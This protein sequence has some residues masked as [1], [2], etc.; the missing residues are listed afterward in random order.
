MGF[1]TARERVTL[2]KSADPRERGRVREP[3]RE[4]FAPRRRPTPS[5]PNADVA[6][7][8]GTLMQRVSETSLQK[9]DDLIAQLQRRREQL[10]NESARI[11]RAIVEYARLNQTTLQ[12]TR[13][14]AESLAYLHRV[15]DAPGI[16]EPHAGEEPH[17]ALASE[18]SGQRGNFLGE[19]AGHSPEAGS[20]ARAEDA[21]QVAAEHE[22]YVEDAPSVMEPAEATDR[23]DAAE[24]ATPAA[25]EVPSDDTRYDPR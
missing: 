2:G 25:D 7:H 8:V 17:T 21:P 14:I 22:P 10:L 20:A 16:S 3:M 5:N 15:P 23:G 1:F 11:E 24:V 13:T 19:R 9:I 18:A 4:D 6:S 12:S